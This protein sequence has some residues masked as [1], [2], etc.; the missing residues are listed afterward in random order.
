[1]NHFSDLAFII[2]LEEKNCFDRKANVSRMQIV[3]HEWTYNLI[4]CNS[5]AGQWIIDR[6]TKNIEQS[7]DFGGRDIRK[8]SENVLTREFQLN[9]RGTSVFNS[10]PSNVVV[11]STRPWTSSEKSV[12]LIWFAWI[13][14]LGYMN[15]SANRKNQDNFCW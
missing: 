5:E 12:E 15:A 8:Q 14:L 10:L 9:P 11:K 3:E 1:M 7:R 6:N 4:S 2:E 13:V